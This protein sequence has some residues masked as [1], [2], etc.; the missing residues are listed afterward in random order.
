MP[1][2][3]YVRD[4]VNN[5]NVQL[6]VDGSNKLSVNDSVAAGHLSALASIVNPSI[7]TAT[8]STIP[9]AIGVGNGSLAS[10]DGKLT[11]QGTAAKQGDIETAINAVNS[12]LSGTISVS[13]SAAAPAR[14]NG[15]LANSALKGSGDLSA[16]VNGSNYR[17]ASVFGSSS[18]NSAKVRVHL[19]H[20]NTNFYEDHTASFFANASNGHIA[21]HWDL[22]APY[23]KIEFVDGATYTLEYAL[24]D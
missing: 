16:S 11:S 14:A 1:S 6:E 3:M 5:K 4:N 24:I 21:G 8:S 7:A 17:K 13:S 19:S 9:S 23:F 10:I 18:S 12:T 22:N 15:N 2:V 20:D